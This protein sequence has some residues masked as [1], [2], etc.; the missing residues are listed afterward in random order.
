[1]MDHRVSD[2]LLDIS[3]QGS[4]FQKR[5]V[6]MDEKLSGVYNLP[7]SFRQF[8]RHLRKA[9]TFNPFKPTLPTAL[10]PSQQLGRGHFHFAQSAG[11]RL[12]LLRSQ[13]TEPPSVIPSPYARCLLCGS[14][15]FTRT[16]P[17]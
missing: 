9:L 4:C 11:P 3:E 7:R 13:P 8:L 1:M 12:P 2:N 5:D 17:R 6:L 14:R 16:M 15:Q 10:S